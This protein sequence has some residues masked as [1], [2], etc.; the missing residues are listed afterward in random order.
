VAQHDAFIS[1]SHTADSS[2]VSA[3]QQLL[4]KTGRPW[5]KYRGLN[6]YRDTTNLSAAPHLWEA[7]ERTLNESC[8]LVLLA[9]P[10]A[11]ASRWVKREVEYWL[12]H[13]SY[14]TLIIVLTSGTIVWN[15][16]AA[17]FDKILTTALPE[18]IY[19]KFLGEPLWVDLTRISN[20]GQLQNN[21]GLLQDAV[22]TIAAAIH[23]LN[24]EQLIGRERRFKNVFRSILAGV[25]I[26]L[27]VLAASLYVQFRYAKE[28]E[29]IAGLQRDSALTNKNLA[30]ANA[31]KADSNA[32]EASR[33]KVEAVKQRDETKRQLII[34]QSNELAIR[35][36]NSELNYGKISGPEFDGTRIVET[37]NL[38][39]ASYRMHPNNDSRQLLEKYLLLLT[40]KPLSVRSIPDQVTDFSVNPSVALVAARFNNGNLL[41]YN[42]FSKAEFWEKENYVWGVAIQPEFGGNF[43]IS[44]A[45]KKT[46]TVSIRFRSVYGFQYTDDVIPTPGI[47]PRN[48]QYSM[49]GKKL[50]FTSPD[51]NFANN[52]YMAD[53]ATHTFSLQLKGIDDYIISQRDT[54][55][56]VIKNDTICVYDFADNISSH[57]RRIH[58]EKILNADRI[59][60]DRWGNF[61]AY[62][63][64]GTVYFD[65]KKYYT[66]DPLISF[67]LNS[68]IL[69]FCFHQSYGQII[70]TSDRKYNWMNGFQY[71]GC[72]NPRNPDKERWRIIHPG[73]VKQMTVYSYN[74]LLTSTENKLYTW[75][76]IPDDV[77]FDKQQSQLHVLND[78]ALVDFA[79]KQ[80]GIFYKDE[81]PASK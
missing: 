68:Y 53:I 63:N 21:Q 16:S 44:I 73:Y 29:N 40:T 13:K 26:V 34:A 9:S 20:S 69:H 30:D 10:E 52:L 6:I 36:I 49:D 23:G 3:I 65:E 18:A 61:A 12:T 8:F 75:K 70:F 59:A 57:P 71:I 22:Y 76:T 15:D 67:R 45:D 72:T 24:K 19:G 46:K 28:Q 33:Q 5:Y 54:S 38:A 43:A 51:G 35:A 66:I 55:L 41:I 14:D 77:D 31:R 60:V 50:F 27:T 48:L 56:G 79:E 42:T 81:R 11:A 62:N 7:I 39:L 17:D 32:N 4:Q 64:G 25:M 58:P 1:Y 78:S 37:L 80:L 47:Y 2:L 74:T